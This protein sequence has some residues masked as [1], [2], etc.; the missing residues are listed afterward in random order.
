M[1]QY[2][3]S[4]QWI[5]LRVGWP[6]TQIEGDGPDAVLP[7][8]LLNALMRPVRTAA[9]RQDRAEYLSLR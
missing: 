9:A 2:R 8:P 6:E 7:F 5:P 4:V 3:L 1:L